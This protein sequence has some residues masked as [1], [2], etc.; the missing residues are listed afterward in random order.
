MFNQWPGPLSRAV[1][2]C[3]S[4]TCWCTKS[5]APRLHIYTEVEHVRL[6][7][8]ISQVEPVND[9]RSSIHRHV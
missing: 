7:S 8:D 9:L 1:K 2:P 5:P 6:T 4:Q 3:P